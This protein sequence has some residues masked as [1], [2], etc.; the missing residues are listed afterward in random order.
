MTALRMALAVLVG[1]CAATSVMMRVFN[2]ASLIGVL[3]VCAILATSDRVRAFVRSLAATAEGSAAGERT[4][5]DVLDRP[6]PH[7]HLEFDDG[8]RIESGLEDETAKR[9]GGWFLAPGGCPCPVDH[10]DACPL[11]PDETEHPAA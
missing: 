1:V 10:T 7:M 9:I 4:V 3:A 11:D 8:T 6:G 2:G 5:L